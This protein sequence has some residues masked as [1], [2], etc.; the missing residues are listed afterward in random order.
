MPTIEEIRKQYPQYGDMSDKALADAMHEKFYADMPQD[1]F[2]QKVGLPQ[3]S[4][5][6]D[7]AKSFGRGVAKGAIG[8]AGLPGDVERLVGKGVEA[9]GTAIG[10][11]K[12]PSEAHAGHALPS[13]AQI[14]HGVESVTGKFG[15]PETTAGKYAESVGEFVPSAFVGPGGLLRKG[16]ETVLGGLGAEAGGEAFGEPGRFVGGMLGVGGAGIAAAEGQSRKLSKMLPD[17]DAHEVASKAG[18]KAIEDSRLQATN[19]SI[20]TLTTGLK[21]DLENRL[22]DRAD[23]PAIFTAIEN[24]SKGGGEVASIMALFENLGKV[25]PSAGEKYYAAQ[26]TREG[27]IDWMDNLKPQDL[28]TGDAQFT[29]AM[30]DQ[31]RG[32]WSAKKKLEMLTEQQ[33][34][35]AR[36]AAKSGSGANFENTLRQ[37]MDEILNSEK[38]SRGLAPNVRDEIVKAVE[39]N[40]YRNS[41]RAVGK[42]APTGPVSAMPT[43]GA[44]LIGGAGAATALATTGFVAKWLAEYLTKRQIREVEDLI[45]SQSPIG[46]PVA[47]QIAT[48]VPNYGAILPAAA[49]RAG[50][51]SALAQPPIEVGARPGYYSGQ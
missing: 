16:A 20:S 5:W 48:Q 22:V 25:P 34:K 28:V 13:S 47:A 33:D 44:D 14:E 18:Y 51:G 10:L 15:Q 42:W 30:W 3:P 27:I 1:D 32:N 6:T 19:A 40:W 39:G 29:V 43:I 50:A 46:K 7:V 31:A 8:L 4:A 26:M 38:K 41:L 21:A 24:L 37:R 11:P 49:L 12:P 45:K 35:A 17:K 23:A 36:Q 9:A 2:Y